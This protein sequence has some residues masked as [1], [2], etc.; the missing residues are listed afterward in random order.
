MTYGKIILFIIA[1]AAL[2]AAIW[3]YQKDKEIDPG[4]NDSNLE[5][6]EAEINSEI[7][8]S[9]GGPVSTGASQGGQ[10]EHSVSIPALINKQY[11]G[12][13]L[14]L[15]DI[16]DDNSV[17]TRYYITY[18]SGELAISGILNLPKGQGPFPL[19]ILNHGHIDTDL[20]TNGRGLR[21]EQD[22]LARTGY[23]VLHTD[24]RNHAQSGKDGR[25]DLAVRLSYAEDAVNAV[26]A[27][28]DA[29]LE[30]V[31]A[32]RV[33]MLGHSMGGGVT[34]SSL[35]IDPDLIDAAVLYAPVSGNMQ[36]SYHRWIERRPESASKIVELYGSPET[37]PDF[38]GDVNAE[39]FYSRISAPVKI[40]HGTADSS[41]PLAWS[42]E[43]LALLQSAG[44]DG[45]LVIYDNA[46]HEFVL[47]WQ[48]FMEE[49]KKF[50][51]KNI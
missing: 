39:N 7:T 6:Q 13:D 11:D 33:G 9:E 12:R 26:Y 36:D 43:T 51:D 5:I 10:V 21:R 19:L 46:P 3:Y 14:V 20:Y 38:W 48:N 15:G 16:L 24:Y 44:K 45:S 35:V 41:V 40:F 30:S 22:Y 17:Y 23:A 50:F 1:I 28:R 27:V 2:G 4:L 32:S 25:D 18:K 37:A 29:K 47:D 42:Q 49:T 8:E 34:L 31:D